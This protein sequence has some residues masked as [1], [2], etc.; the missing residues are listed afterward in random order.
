MERCFSHRVDG[1]TPCDNM[2]KEAGEIPTDVGMMMWHG[3]P[4]CGKSSLAFQ[5]AFDIVRA[6]TPPDASSSD[7]TLPYVVLVCHESMKNAPERFVPIDPCESCQTPVKSGRDVL[8]WER[9][10]IKY[11][12]NA[13]QLCNFACSL[14]VLGGKSIA[15]IVD[16]FDLFWED[17]HL[18][19][20]LYRCLAYLKET[21]D[22]MRRANGMGQ[23]VVL[24]TS[25]AYSKTERHRLRRWFALLLE[26]LPHAQNDPHTYAM[27]E[28]LPP[29]P[30]SSASS[31]LRE[32]AAY[33][34]FFPVP[35]HI[36]YHFEPNTQDQ[37]GHF[38]FLL[39]A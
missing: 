6:A 10:R 17:A 27:Q 14:H 21:S 7:A 15:L 32:W 20:D 34:P 13:S 4:K 12:Q 26:L 8:H 31:S 22:F 5:Y 19:S 1:T 33:L 30:F 2:I 28:E 35:Y 25:A 16:D 24:S 36:L 9:V 29:P 11:L 18:E 38:R 3:P 39:A 37:D 23:V